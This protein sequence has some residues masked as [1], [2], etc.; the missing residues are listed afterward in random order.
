MRT[1]AAHLRKGVAS[2]ILEHIIEEAKRRSYTR[3][4]LETG[5]MEAFAPARALY[6]SFGFVIC[7]PFADYVPD[8]YSV[9]MTRAL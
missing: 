4:S 6:T 7:E 1:A 9:F 8:P 5:S 2:K 3:L